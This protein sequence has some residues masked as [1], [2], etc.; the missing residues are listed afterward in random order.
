MRKCGIT[1]L[2]ER[3]DESLCRGMQSLL[4]AAQQC[5]RRSCSAIADRLLTKV[6]FLTG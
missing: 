6:R 4:T 3:T 1:I 2:L 5:D